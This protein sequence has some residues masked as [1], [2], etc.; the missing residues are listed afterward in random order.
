MINKFIFADAP[1][2]LAIASI[3]RMQTEKKFK[4][5]TIRGSFVLSNWPVRPCYFILIYADEL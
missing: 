1:L 5:I 3:I 2:C 4:F